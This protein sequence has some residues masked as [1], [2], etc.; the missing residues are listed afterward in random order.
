MVRILP[1]AGRC[2][3]LAETQLAFVNGGTSM[4][5]RILI[6]DDHEVVRSVALDKS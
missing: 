3:F 6:A 4:M 2:D 1:D 5:T